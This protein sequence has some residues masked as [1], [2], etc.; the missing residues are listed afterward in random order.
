MEVLFLDAPFSGTVELS[1]DTLSY[2]KKKKYKT[3]ALYASVQFVNNLDQ[4]RKRLA[5][6]NID[7]ITSQADRTHVKGQLLGC[8]NY[9]HSLNLSKDDSTAV[10]CYLYIGDGKPCFDAGEGIS[11]EDTIAIIHKAVFFPK[12]IQMSPISV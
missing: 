9:H 6:N 2:L 12:F 4:I 7:V 1:K 5:E 8:D 10:D 3:V 11:S